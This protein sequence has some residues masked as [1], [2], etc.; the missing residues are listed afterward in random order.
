MAT[1]PFPRLCALA[2]AAL[3]TACG[4]ELQDTAAAQ[5]RLASFDQHAAMAASTPHDA[6]PW[7]FVGPVRMN[8]RLVD[9]DVHPSAPATIYIAS[10]NGGVLKTT[11]EG[12]NW[13][14]IFD[15]YPTTSIGDI[16][17][18]PTDPNIVWV[19]T[20]EA[21]ILR[22]SM[23]GTGIYKSTDAGETF[24][25]MGLTDTQHISR[26][27]INPQD[28]NVIYVAAAGHEYTPNPER[29]VYKSTDG[30]TTW[31][32]AFYKDEKTAVIDLAIDPS[33]PD[34][35]YAGT[36]PRMRYR[37]ND[38]KPGPETGIY[39]T[40]DGG[41][42]WNALTEGLPDFSAGEHE[43]VGLSVCASDP[44]V[45]YAAI[46]RAAGPRDAVGAE[47]YRSD[48]KGETWRR[49]DGSEEARGTFSSYGW[50]FGQVRADPTNPDTVYLMGLS[51]R[52]S[53]DGG[54]T[55]EGLRG[56]H[57]DY[58]AMWINPE[59]PTHLVVGNDGG[60]MISHDRFA[61]QNHPTNLPIAQ[62]YNLDV[63]Q[64]E[65]RFSVY[66]CC[67]D[68]GAYRGDVD[69]SNGRNRIIRQRWEG[70][71]GDEA[72]RHAVNPEDANIVYSVSR[73]GGGPR[74]TVYGET[75]DAD[76][77]RPKEDAS[78]APTFPEGERKR[79]QWVSPVIVSSHDSKRILYGAQFVFLTDDEG[80]NWRKISPDLTNVDPE[81]QGNIAHAI[82]FAISES[83]VEKGVIYAGTDD[84]N[85][86]VTRDEGET[87]TN[88]STSLPDGRCVAG[89]EASHFDAGTVFIAVNGKRHDDFNA[90]IY[91]STNYGADW[92]LI[93]GGIP[94]VPANVVKQ[95]P[96]NKDLLYVGTDRG[97]Y[98][99]TDGGDTWHVL[100][101]DLP[102]AFVH[103]LKI[104]HVEDY[105]V[106]ACHGRGVWVLDIRELRAGR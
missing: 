49:P 91:K 13:K 44:N 92:E 104:Q 53:D 54:K 45:I 86:Q 17:I 88:V 69:L 4:T 62:P 23:A 3:S 77:R 87:W 95:D 42:T 106:I 74:R 75:V 81:K 83:P 21:N 34:I 80:Q 7:Q 38:P 89:V 27:L 70:A 29:G 50:F 19:G 96:G 35:L 36:A 105:A 76:G 16:A 46:N 90:Y 31:T 98:V 22:S 102:T 24:E 56:S 94:D 72:G 8:G 18:D 68:T 28:S 64:E 1:A 84:G 93:S 61:S 55:W 25:H 103:D 71:T 78:I 58:H 12:E 11:D 82:I 15:K 41:E 97:V 10:A 57:V 5:A 20:G 73:Y 101:V 48:D 99:T 59:D 52:R 37:W 66:M 26:I 43:R 85:V 67:Q 14:H 2:V 63:S 79:A 6:H 51:F 100:G 65:G 40:T 32:H 30:G 60:V 9:V 47:L 33:D 39:K